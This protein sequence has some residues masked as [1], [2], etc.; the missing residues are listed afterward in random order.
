MAPGAVYL[1]SRLGLPLVAMGFGYDRP[2]RVTRAWDQFAIPRP[3][4]RARAVVSPDLYIPSG[5]DRQGLEH[6]RQRVEALLNRLCD[7]AESW[8]ASGGR[9]RGERLVRPG[10]RQEPQ[11]TICGL[12]RL[13]RRE[14]G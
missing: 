11:A 10:P 7:E 14:T 5:L 3:F 2:W 4:S 1:A 8:A 12:T 13:E 9:R 6:F